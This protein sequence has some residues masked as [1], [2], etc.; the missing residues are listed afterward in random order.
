MHPAAP[1]A[2]ELAR[3]RPAV[4][5]G[6]PQAD[7]DLVTSVAFVPDDGSEP[8]SPELALIDPALAARLRADLSEPAAEPERVEPPVEA[9]AEAALPLEDAESAPVEPP[10]IVIEP[11]DVPVVEAPEPPTASIHVLR[12]PAPVEEA[13]LV[14][15]ETVEPVAEPRPEPH[16]EL[17]PAPEPR[18]ELAPEPESEIAPQPV[19]VPRPEPVEPAVP[20][21]RLPVIPT[22]PPSRSPRPSSVSP[23][24]RRSRMWQLIVLLATIVLF[25][26]VVTVG[27]VGV[28]ELRDRTGSSGA[29]AT[30]EPPVAA[31]PQPGDET[32]EPTATP[33]PTPK[34]GGGSGAPV[35]RRFAWAPVD[36]ATS[37]RFELF[38]GDEQ[39]LVATTKSPAY[40]LPTSWRHEGRSE[41]LTSG[42]YR[43]YVWPVLASGPADAAVVQASLDVP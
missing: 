34:D 17:A 39:V 5:T 20:V 26:G 7:D 43:W 10:P 14:R 8:V 18:P 4:K 16:L 15:E 9:E 1:S 13:E 11:E 27:V 40:Q 23:L 3:N 22:P 36:G 38:R 12:A 29:T 21:A 37:Y 42:S 32:D 41:R 2:A 19:I 33:T 30:S 28:S 31:A 24:R 6:E 35:P 25:A